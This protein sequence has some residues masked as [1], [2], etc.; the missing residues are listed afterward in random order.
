MEKGEK[1]KSK[2]KPPPPPSDI[3]SSD[4]SDSSNDDG[5]SDEEI[6]YIT[7]NLDGKTKLFITK[8]MKDLES[9]QSKLES[10]EKTLI[11]QKD[12]Y[13]ASKE[14]LAQGFGQRARGPCYHKEST[15]CSQEKVL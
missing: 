6:N 14:A 9:V 8:L 11:K 4:I 2:S 3:S 13:I 5:S 7:K 15:S 1:I 12:L 10:R